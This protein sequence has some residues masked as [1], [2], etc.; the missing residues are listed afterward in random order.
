MD[1]SGEIFSRIEQPQKPI[2]IPGANLFVPGP[3]VVGPDRILDRRVLDDEKP[4]PLHI[5]A[6]WS[7][8]SGL[9]DLVDQRVWHRIWLQS[10]HRPGGP[11][12]L[13]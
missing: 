8:D 2:P 7:A 5:A 1:V 3:L 13:E 4:P 9:K 10:P 6:T 12:D 11:H